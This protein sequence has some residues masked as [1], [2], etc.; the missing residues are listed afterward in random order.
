MH[1]LSC[2]NGFYLHENEKSYPY[3]RLSTYPRF[4]I[5]ARGNLEMAYFFSPSPVIVLDVLAKLK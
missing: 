1:N 5:E 3:Q 2:E 4:D